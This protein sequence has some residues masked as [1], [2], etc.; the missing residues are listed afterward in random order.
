MFS[1]TACA[2]QQKDGFEEMEQ[3]LFKVVKEKITDI[4][5]CTLICKRDIQRRKRTKRLFQEQ[6]S[7]MEI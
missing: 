1:T 6:R 7:K 5:G 4:A 3:A 2:L